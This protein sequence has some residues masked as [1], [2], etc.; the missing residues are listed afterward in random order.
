MK[1]GVLEQRQID[2]AG[3]VYDAIV[4]VASHQL[5]QEA[6]LVH[7]QGA[8]GADE[9][10]RAQQQAQLRDQAGDSAILALNRHQLLEHPAAGEKLKSHRGSRP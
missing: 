4:G 5:D 9:D 8:H 2:F 10:R 7:G 1:V 6:L 3:H